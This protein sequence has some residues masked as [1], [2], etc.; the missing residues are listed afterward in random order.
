M[1]QTHDSPSSRQPRLKEIFS[2]THPVLINSDLQP[3]FLERGE[4]DLSKF[5]VVCE[6]R[7][8]DCRGNHITCSEGCHKVFVRNIELEFGDYKKVV[9]V[10]TGLVYKVPTRHIVEKGLRFSELKDFPLWD[11]DE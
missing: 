1:V 6:A 2:G 11:V 4:A 5:C 10:T 7:V 8:P 3:R 9:D